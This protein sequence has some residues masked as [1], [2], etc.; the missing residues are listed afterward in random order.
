MS[1]IKCCIKCQ[2]CAYV[3]YLYLASG[4]G[5]K[6]VCFSPHPNARIRGYE[7]TRIAGPQPCRWVSAGQVSV[8]KFVMSCRHG[9]GFLSAIYFISALLFLFPLS[10]WLAFLFFFLW[11]S[12]STERHLHLE[13]TDA[14]IQIRIQLQLRR[15]RAAA[16]FMLSAMACLFLFVFHFLWFLITPPDSSPD[17]QALPFSPIKRCI[18]Y[19]AAG[20]GDFDAESGHCNWNWN[21][22]RNRAELSFTAA[23]QLHRVANLSNGQKDNSLHA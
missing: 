3:Q 16:A 4:C 7:N 1:D 15:W 23:G 17:G 10:L 12:H 19:G 14:D 6:C 11:H 9:K 2:F 18:L 21:W 22:N 5:H 20:A 13:P 8:I